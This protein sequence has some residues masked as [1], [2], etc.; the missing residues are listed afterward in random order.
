[1]S[2]LGY[3]I[4]TWAIRVGGRR[5]NDNIGRK[6]NYRG[7]MEEDEMYRRLQNKLAKERARQG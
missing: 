6:G 5:I 2:K 4:E 7:I 1:M 3:A